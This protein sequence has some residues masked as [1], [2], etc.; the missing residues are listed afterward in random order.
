[1][2]LTTLGALPHFAFEGMVNQKHENRDIRVAVTSNN[3]GL[4]CLDE[5]LILAR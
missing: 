3:L 5:Q 2:L 4:A 1:M